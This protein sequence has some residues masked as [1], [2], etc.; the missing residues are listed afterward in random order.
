MSAEIRWTRDSVGDVVCEH[1]TAADVHC[2]NC[3]SGFLF[4]VE[5][6]RCLDD[7]EPGWCPYCGEPEDKCRAQGGCADAEDEE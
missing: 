4:D 6:C 3:H 5:S 7:Y 1:G 2:C